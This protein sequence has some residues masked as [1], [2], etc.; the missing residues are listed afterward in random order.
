MTAT[1]NAISRIAV[2]AAA[3]LGVTSSFALAQPAAPPPPATQPASLDQP[4]PMEFPA[5]GIELKTLVDV[6][7]KRLKTPILYDDNVL[8]KRLIVRVPVNA[9]ESALLGILQSALKMKQLAL[10]DA[11]SPG[12]KQIVPVQ[13]LSAVARPVAAGAK[14]EPGE[15]VVQLL[16]LKNADPT[17]VS[18]AV[19]PLLTSP[20]GNVQVIPGQRTL[21]ITDYPTVIKRVE[22]LAALLDGA[23]PQVQVQFV[24]LKQAE[25]A[26]LAPIATS[27]LSAKLPAQ[28][29]GSLPPVT[30]TADDRVNQLVVVASAEQMAEV[31][32]IIQGLDEPVNL[33]TKVYRLKSLSPERLDK[34][35]KNLLGTGASKR[36]Y[37]STPDKESQS[38]VVS[39]TPEVHQRIEVMTKELDIVA[40][41]SESPIRFYKLKNTTAAQ[42]LGT[43]GSLFGQAGGGGGLQ[44]EGDG[45]G[46]S[47]PSSA[48]PR[49]G[50]SSIGSNGQ[51]T[52]GATG[53]A[54]ARNSTPGAPLTAGAASPSARTA[55]VTASSNLRSGD[56]AG[57]FNYGSRGSADGSD[58]ANNSLSVRAPDAVV[59]ADP[60]TNSIIV[61]APPAVQQ[62]Y[63]EL[64]KR[65][66][67]RRPQVQIECTLVTLDTSD[68]ANFAVDIAQLGGFGVNK[69][70][71]FSSFGVATVD[72]KT[73][74]LAPVPA[75]GGTA[76][77][78]SPRVA[79]VAIRALSTH[80]RARL[81]SAP[82]ILVNDNGRGRLQ[83]VNQQPFA[84]IL[85][86]ATSQSRTGLGGQAE[87]GTT[88]TVEPHISQDDYLQLVY[89]I[90]LSSFTGSAQAGLPP[91]S[92]KNA[93]DSTVT[94]PD[95]YTIVVGGLNQKSLT[96][97]INSLP[98]IDQIP[99]VNLLFGGRSSQKSDTTLFVFIRPIILRDDKFDDLRYLSGQQTKKAGL[100]PEHPSSEP[101]PLK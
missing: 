16:Q 31:L 88:I 24:P 19:R 80:S 64:I 85:D 21:V 87:A 5:E 44:F 1:S 49:G 69:L 91:P 72:I 15:A 66:D 83:S 99:I 57:R 47:P 55:G 94:I 13:N 90:E 39:A 54:S 89:S 76:A 27:L 46:D 45:T 71:T 26:T 18:E 40:P 10:I 48:T 14:G 77:L 68:G 75:T 6:V 9:P 20:G 50:N 22:E 28:P 63:A 11:E 67:Q 101:I 78:L 81:V 37:Q 51:P 58:A 92:Q 82:Q 53:A 95:S 65:L 25:A 36:T 23:G 43:I 12:W 61:I 30:V 96:T 7:T 35:V 60:N 8:N 59:A 2:A 97:A 100:A 4:V 42:V 41:E 34:L 3:V 70:L 74:S 62:S 29:G 33:Q 73:G 17:R 38:L 93:V 32:K 98:L 79:D 56:A 52:I 84:E 86:T